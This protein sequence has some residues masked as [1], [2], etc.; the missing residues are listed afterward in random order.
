MG[1]LSALQGDRI[2]LDTNIW[3]Y[4]CFRRNW[5]R[6]YE[7]TVCHPRSLDD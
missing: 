4:H 1:L 2:Y 7:Y 5:R 3:I 6:K